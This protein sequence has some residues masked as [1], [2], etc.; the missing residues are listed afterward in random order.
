MSRGPW[1]AARLPE[2]LLRVSVD[3]SPEAALSLKP[4]PLPS[5]EMGNHSF[6]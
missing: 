4:P 1:K 2:S 5:T 3:Q 6:P